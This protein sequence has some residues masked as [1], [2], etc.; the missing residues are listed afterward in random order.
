MIM[1]IQRVKSPI[2]D[3]LIN[4]KED[5]VTTQKAKTVL[6]ILEAVNNSYAGYVTKATRTILSARSQLKQKDIS[7]EVLLGFAG[8][9]D[10]LN[11]F[12]STLA[13]QTA[14]LRNLL[15]GKYIRLYEEDK[16]LIEDLTLNTAEMI[17]R[18]NSRLKT[19][20]TIRQSYD[21]ISASELNKTFRRLTSIS[22]F[23]MIPT[24]VSGL[25]GMNVALPYGENPRAFWFV[26]LLIAAGASVLFYI[27]HRKKWL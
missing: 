11:E 8:M 19:I 2:L 16:D 9:E 6:Q 10:D 15:G 7:N 27:F 20:V 21:A 1:T 13:P 3:P 5:V 23:M 22:I 4:G 14:M 12:L 25:Y 26:V 17:E 24:I 18:V